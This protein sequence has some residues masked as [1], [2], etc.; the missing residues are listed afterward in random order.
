MDD[1]GAGKLARPHDMFAHC[2]IRLWDHTI[3]VIPYLYLTV[4]GIFRSIGFATATRYVASL[5]CL[6]YRGGGK[7]IV[8]LHALNHC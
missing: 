2:E 4:I 6:L 8:C 1:G 5:V 3:G 7:P